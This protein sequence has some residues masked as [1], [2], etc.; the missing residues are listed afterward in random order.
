MEFFKKINELL[1]EGCTLVMNVA[2]KDGKLVIG[3]LPGNPLV[4]DAGAKNIAPLNISGTADELDEGFLEAIAGP[5]SR[6]TGLLVDMASFEKGEQEAKAKSEMVKKQQEEKKRKEDEFKGYIAL[7]KEN[8]EADKFKDAKLCL[9]NAK[10]SADGS[11]AQKNVISETSALIE[12]KLG[13]DLFGAPEDKS[14]G[15][16]IKLKNGSSKPAPK[17]KEGEDEDV[18]DEDNQEQ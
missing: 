13:G 12:K 17:K 8:L 9:E 2:K 11:E 6:V 14:D 15:K 16:N 5:I 3:V 10:G 18:E 1:G 7:A 4:K